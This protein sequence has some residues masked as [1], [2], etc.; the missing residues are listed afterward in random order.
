MFY[1]IANANTTLELDLSTFD[2][3]SVTTYSNIF[4]GMRS[5]GKIWV[6]DATAQSWILTNSGNSNLTSANVLIKS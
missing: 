1:S 6:G 4:V 5:T 3:S 2:F